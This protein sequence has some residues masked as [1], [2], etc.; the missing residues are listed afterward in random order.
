MTEKLRLTLLQPEL[1]WEDSQANR[2]YLGELL[3]PVKETDLIILPEMCTTGFSM[4]PAQ[5]AEKAEDS[6]SLK[7]LV[8]LAQQKSCAIA[9]GLMIEQEGQYYNRLYFVQPDG[10]YQFY[11]KKHLFTLAG[12]EKIYQSGQDLLVVNYMGWRIKPL[13]CYDLR[14]PVWS[15][16]TD[17]TDLMLYIAN[18]PERRSHAWKSLLPARAI[19]NMCYVAGVNRVGQDGNGVNHSGDSAVYDVLGT[20]LLQMG[21]QIEGLETIQLSKSDLRQSREKFAFL[22]DRDHFNLEG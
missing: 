3:A 7:W 6:A 20:P 1:F 11:S 14:F 8:R 10:S 15:R 18:W 17:D 4:R 12:E 16:N 19:E 13:I 21:P 9:A 2:A 5:F 22:Q